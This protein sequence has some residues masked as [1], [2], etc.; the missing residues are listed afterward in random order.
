MAIISPSLKSKIKSWK[1]YKVFRRYILW[2][3]DVYAWLLEHYK[4]LLMAFQ[5]NVMIDP[6]TK[7][8]PVIWKMC[9]VK[10]TGKFRVGYDV[11]FD[12]INAH[13]ITIEDGVWISS[14]CTLL[15][16]KRDIS[17]YHKGV[18]YS[19]LPAKVAPIHIGRNAAIGMG[20][21]I[22]P[23]VTIGEGAVIGSG[24]L[25]TKD[26]PAWSIAYG[27]PAVVVKKIE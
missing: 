10:A 26:I 11:Y 24:S 25:V 22:M 1:Y 21:M 19:S 4:W 14:R 9:G 5:K 16:H 15:C 23:G 27:R 8:R 20:T 12:A 6:A 13:L 18:I 7:W 17:G 3:I 2:P